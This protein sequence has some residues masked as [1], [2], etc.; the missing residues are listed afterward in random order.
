MTHRIVGTA[1]HID[2]GKTALIRALTG[3]DTD[4]LKEEQQRG[5]TIDLGFA[6]LDLGGDETV[7]V[8][9]VPGH[10]RFVRN[11]LAGAGGIDTVLLVVAADE[12]VKP[13][14]RE[15]FEICRLLGV[16]TGVIALTKI[17][18]ADPELTELVR[19][20]VAELVAGSFLQSA[21]TVEVSSLTG[22][23]VE[24]VRRALA[25]AI[26]SAP[27]PG[28]PDF[29]RL[30]VDRAFTVRG[31][32]TVVTGTLLSGEIEEG[33][34]LVLWPGGVPVRV[35]R[36]EVHEQEV[37]RAASGQRTA[38]NLAGSLK[39]APQR[40]DLLAS[41]GRMSPSSLIDARVEILAAAKGGIRDQARVRFHI[42]TADVEARLRLL[43]GRRELPAGGSGLAQLRLAHP[44]AATVGDHFILRRPSPPLTLGGGR[45]VDP[46]PRKHRG[47]LPAVAERLA[48]LESA[49]AAE[50]LTLLL[51]EAGGRGL[52][53]ADLVVR[54]GLSP[55][56]LERAVEAS[57][58]EGRI[59]T[60]GSAG[61]GLLADKAAKALR[62][63]MA[64]LLAD[65]HRRRP[66][67]AGMSLE[68]LRRR[69]A[70]HTPDSLVE[71]LLR[72]MVADGEIRLA[73]QRAASASHQVS[74]PAEEEETLRQVAEEIRRGGFDPPTPDRLLGERGIEPAR[75]QAL[76]RLLVERGVLAR[77]ADGYHL[78]AAVV[79][80]L[81]RE[82]ARRRRDD[83][84]IDV[85]GFK[86]LTGTTRRAAI[87]LLEYLD[88][89]RVTTRR[90][91]RRYIQEPREPA[92]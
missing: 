35:R 34:G 13:Q 20:E 45:V 22:E 55:G 9:D 39:Q 54:T 28:R 21:E 25:R 62:S 26:Q 56:A 65:Y 50:R 75:Q 31:F 72:G 74:L 79:E 85:A 24:E 17:D 10:E 52:S 43:G 67:D 89:E 61:G 46:C 60:D 16:T 88:A 1:G 73:G 82:L 33:D 86:Q 30:P 27:E 57:S 12:S 58:R 44:L 37:P 76:V 63:R 64:A 78:H 51:E 6:P 90:G 19:Q 81:K 69:G 36:V 47:R 18:L 5:I 2:H 29:V 66:L 53:R 49:A 91:D 7:G 40:G 14:T 71:S 42:G 87:P 80:E 38:L 48:A 68:E 83:P 77:I 11:M 41:P 32:G 15:H 4:R 84:F 92:R 23:G 3:V 8:V 70:P 59:L